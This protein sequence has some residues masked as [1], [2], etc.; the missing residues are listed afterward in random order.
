M[1]NKPIRILLGIILILLAANLVV[2]LLKP[3]NSRKTEKQFKALSQRLDSTE[4]HLRAA[5]LTIDS[6]MASNQ[7]SLRNLES[8]NRE[9]ER[10][11][12]D[13]ETSRKQSTQS[14]RNLRRELDQNNNQLLRLREELKPLK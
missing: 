9:V 12:N 8:M 7:S 14:I 10:I 11:R 3:G 2:L 13:Y 1:N 5:R 4:S 6:L